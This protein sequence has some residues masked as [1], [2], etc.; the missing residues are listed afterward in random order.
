MKKAQVEMVGLV[1]VVVIIVIGIILYM[2]F[3][4]KNQ[5]PDTKDL[6]R[7][8]SFLVALSETTVPGCS[9]P[10]SRV[11]QSCVLNEATC[12]QP[13][14]QLETVMDQTAQ[15]ALAGSKYSLRVED[16]TGTVFARVEDDCTKDAASIIAAPRQPIPFGNGRTAYL[17]LTL[18]R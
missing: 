7:S 18:C 17:V 5:A 14:E 13:C 2:S 8:N 16:A 10:F 9:D 11:V 6:Q 1:F 12:Q 15:Y 3:A 4:N